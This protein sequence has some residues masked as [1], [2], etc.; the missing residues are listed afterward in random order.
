MA[1]TQLHQ[2][3]L[4]DQT[5]AQSIARQALINSNFDVWQRGT[6]VS[7]SS[8][9]AADRWYNA[10]NGSSNTQS[11]QTFTL[12]QTDVPGNPKYYLRQ[13]V[14]SSAGAG[15]YAGLQYA[16]IEGVG[17]FA[18]QNATLSFYAKADASKNIAVEFLQQF[19]TGGS[20]S[21]LVT[22]IGSQLIPLTTSWAKKTVTIAIPSITGKTLGT[23]GNDALV[24]FFWLD[25][26]SSFNTRSASLGQQSGTFEF[27]QMQV[28]LG[29]EALPY[30]PK[31]FGQELNDCMRYYQKSYLYSV[32]PGSVTNA[33][34]VYHNVGTATTS[35]IY[36]PIYLPVA[37][38]IAPT[39]VRTWDSSGNAERVWKGAVNKA[40]TYQPTYY[41]EKTL[42]IGTTDATSA[43]AVEFLYDANAEL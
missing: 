20:P 10:L 37:M 40:V 38:R 8:G 32:A 1:I 31:S 26:G 24:L 3:R 29:N 33:G 13:V 41:T 19:G 9:I 39:T 27:S 34:C 28:C 25:A 6:S 5:N 15:N 23:D 2:Q 21:A 43:V 11:R 35:A 4:Q 18:G 17:T 22:G 36:A 30:Q 16:G 42:L 14:T 12:G 7:T